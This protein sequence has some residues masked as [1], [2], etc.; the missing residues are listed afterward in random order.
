MKLLSIFALMLVVM[1][2]AASAQEAIA[3]DEAGV[4]WRTHHAPDLAYF[5]Y[6]LATYSV[7]PGR[8]AGGSNA[9][10]LFPGVVTIDPNDW[11]LYTEG[12]GIVYRISMVAVIN[13]DVE[14]TDDLLPLLGTLPLIQYGG[15]VLEGLN[16]ETL[17]IG[18]LPAVR[19]DN[20]PA[21]PAGLASH[22]LAVSDTQIF[23]ITVAEAAN[24]GGDDMDAGQE[25][26]DR[27]LASLRFDV[28]A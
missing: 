28:D 12:H 5:D 10:V 3:T 8:T 19:V 6:P 11:L 4:L 17:E 18:G 25:V 16:I 14:S 2:G 1:T 15:D 21:G 7:R 26:V 22:I 9:S 27:I 23:E 13:E 24:T 20:V